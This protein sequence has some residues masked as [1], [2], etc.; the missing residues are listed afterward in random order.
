MTCVCVCVCV[1]ARVYIYKYINNCVHE[2]CRLAN[3]KV[4]LTFEIPA[5]TRFQ[6]FF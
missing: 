3:W 1:C 5:M 4:T 6:T 2:S